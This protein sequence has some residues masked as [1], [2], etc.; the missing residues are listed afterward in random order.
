M[1][2]AV[3]N[4]NKFYICVSQIYNTMNHLLRILVLIVVIAQTDSLCGQTFSVMRKYDV[5]TGLSDNTVR[6]IMQDSTGYIW[7][8]TRD[9]VNR[10]N[11]TEFT[12]FADSTDP[13]NNTLLNVL[14][15]YPH[16]DRVNVWTATTDGLYLFNTQSKSFTPFDEKTEQGIGIAGAVNDLCYDDDGQLW[17]GTSRGLFVYDERK[18]QLRRYVRSQVDPTSLPD[19]QVISVFR[20]SSGTLWFGTCQGLAK[21]KKASDN[22]AVYRLPRLTKVSHSFEI[23]TLMETADGEI[24]VGTRYDGLLHLD[25]SDGTFTAYPVATAYQGNTWIRALFQY[26][27]DV[28]F[29]GT[30]DGL[31]LFRQKEKS[32]HKLEAFDSKCIYSFSRDREGGVWV[33]TYFDG[34]Y[35]ISPQSNYIKWYYEKH[36][37][38]SLSGNAVS[39]FCEDPGGNLWIATENGGLNYFNPRTEEFTRYM[40][41]G[42]STNISYNNIHALLLDDHRLWIGTFSQGIDVMDLKTRSIVRNYQYNM[43]DSNSIPHN[44]VYSLYKNRYGEIFVGTMRGL[45]QFLPEINKFH[46]FEE[47]RDVFVYDMLEDSAGTLWIA[48]KEGGI[49]RYD[50]KT[51]KFRNYKHSAS[52]AGSLSDNRVIRVYI[53]RIGQLW[54]CT[55]GGGIS[56]YDYD[57]DSFVNYNYQKKLYSHVIYGILDD[58]DGNLWLSSNHGIIKYNPLTEESKLYTHEDGL[59]SNLFNFRSSLKASN[60]LFYFGG[61]EGF[62]CFYPDKLY[63]NTVK[64]TAVISSI[65]LHDS[66]GSAETRK[67]NISRQSEF[68][69]DYHVSSF[70]IGYECLSFVAPSKNRYAYKID[71]VHDDWVYT[72]KHSVT[73]MDLPSGTYKFMVRVANNDGVWS[74]NPCFINLHIEAPFWKTTSAKV[75]YVFLLLLSVCLLLFR[76]SKKQSEKREREKKD[77]ELM[78]SKIQFFTHVAHEIKTPVSLIKAPLEAV[79]ESG[80]WNEETESNLSI[81]RQNTDRLLELIKQLLNFRK[82]DQDGYKLSYSEVDIIPFMKGIIKR[83]A[84][85][86]SSVSIHTE[87]VQEHLVYNVDAE[88]LTK[89]VSNLLTNAF[90]YARTGIWVST[91]EVVVEDAPMLEISVGDDGPG[92]TEVE[93]ARIFGPFYRSGNNNSTETGFGIGLSLVKLLVDKHGGKISV[94]RSSQGGFLITIHLPKIEA[95]TTK[96][97]VNRNEH[98][99]GGHFEIGECNLLI[100]EDTHDMLEF[101]LKNLGY[102][103]N[104]LGATNGKEALKL[105]HNNTVDIIISDIV[106]PEMDGFELLNAV[107]ADKMLCHIPFILLSAQSSVNSKITGLDYGA[108]AYIEKPFSL[109]HIKATIDNLLKNRKVLF[110]RFASMSNLEYGKGEIKRSDFEWLEQ[111]NGIIIR[112]FT[113]EGFTV[114]ILASEMALSRSNLQRKLKGVTGLPPIDYIRLVRLKAAAQFLKEGKYRV[115]EVCYLVGF[116]NH[117]YF[118]RCFQKQFGVLPKDYMKGS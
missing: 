93:A 10:F 16:I 100:V 59:Q 71:Q 33:G 108:D 103:Y 20:D 113:N 21:Y 90:K 67:I 34:I 115:N 28:F 42:S 29:I 96:P 87:F 117:S 111:V 8:G 75:V 22:F 48:T 88:A 65:N 69:V 66:S 89:I 107:R 12:K 17:I 24:W 36:K 44:Y 39:Q 110:E 73:F 118:A 19:N 84:S 83:F 60:G 104:V 82:V 14:K 105:L 43:N 70:E 85:F 80:A 26:S 62:N 31:F 61:V 4:E 23:S 37:Q 5:K 92:V 27:P 97:T 99:S 56:R 49:W 64:P 86:S 1:R 11:G 50:R 98:E 53:D 38:N 9:G 32:L 15:L 55:E 102:N 25:R 78:M 35:Y 47:L 6:T 3:M 106:M 58:K 91:G 81:I 68:T 18:G 77:M 109:S 45:C 2:Q 72:D 51:G 79:F 74:D 63:T 40:A 114:D 112:N 13:S 76:Y 41:N 101:L 116:S 30:E 94:G 52:D 95:S 57:S 54:F 7:L 46:R